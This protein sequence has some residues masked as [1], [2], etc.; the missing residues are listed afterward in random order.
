[1]RI[2]PLFSENVLNAINEC[3]H[4]EAFKRLMFAKRAKEH[5]YDFTKSPGEQ[6]EH[7]PCLFYDTVN[8]RL[9]NFSTD[10]KRLADKIRFFPVGYM[11]PKTRQTAK[12]R[13]R[14][15]TPYLIYFEVN[16]TVMTDSIMLYGKIKT[17]MGKLLMDVKKRFGKMQK[18]V[19]FMVA[20]YSDIE[21][22][23]PEDLLDAMYFMQRY[24]GCEETALTDALMSG[25]ILVG[26]KMNL[27][28][29][30]IF[31]NYA[32]QNM[33]EDYLEEKSRQDTYSAYSL[34]D[35]MEMTSSQ[36][37]AVEFD[38]TLQDEKVP[39]H[40]KGGT[41][42]CIRSYDGLMEDYP[43]MTLLEFCVF[44]VAEISVEE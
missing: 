3:L 12:G 8:N 22:V 19:R 32:A 4:P 17:D 5:S 11:L 10:D 26:D 16:P 6:D 27:M 30:G 31:P 39:V 14:V 41:H 7:V 15:I 36:K 35:F 43:H 18:D 24:A 34:D 23:S 37:P 28:L 29:S 9:E 33:P 40:L 25:N 42:T 2:K 44:P 38:D 1:M 20:D 21:E 13:I